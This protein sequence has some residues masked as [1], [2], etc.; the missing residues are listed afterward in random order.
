MAPYRCRDTALPGNAPWPVKPS[1]L[2]DMSTKR[3]VAVKPQTLL[4]PRLSCDEERAI[5]AKF[6]PPPPTPRRNPMSRKQSPMA[7]NYASYWDTAIDFIFQERLKVAQ[8]NKGQQRATQGVDSMDK[9]WKATGFDPKNPGDCSKWSTRTNITGFD[10]KKYDVPS[11][12]LWNN[13]CQVEAAAAAQ[14]QYAAQQK[15]KDDPVAQVAAKNAE[16]NAAMMDK[17]AVKAATAQ[18]K[19][20]STKKQLPPIA[21]GYWNAVSMANVPCPAEKKG[22]M[23]TPTGKV[24]ATAEM[25]R[26]AKECR[27]LRRNMANRAAGGGRAGALAGFLEGQKEKKRE[28]TIVKRQEQREKAAQKAAAQQTARRNMYLMIGAGVLAVGAVVTVVAS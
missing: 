12:F 10:P 20:E 4:N 7:H 8:A 14:R 28:K 18:K 19:H 5:T 2:S 3:M 17:Q 21:P 11:L 16:K 25:R 24:K 9:R 6:G 22:Y 15:A 27:D 1:K 13:K 23:I 26:Q